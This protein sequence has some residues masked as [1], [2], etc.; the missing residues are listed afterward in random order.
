MKI[1]KE[2]NLYHL[3]EDAASL[4]VANAK[5]EAELKTKES[6]VNKFI[7]VYYS[8]FGCLNLYY[9]WPQFKWIFNQFSLG[10]ISWG[11]VTEFPKEIRQQRCGVFTKRQRDTQTQG[12][13]T[14]QNSL[15]HILSLI[16]LFL[17]ILQLNMISLFPER[18]CTSCK[19]YDIRKLERKQRWREKESSPYHTSGKSQGQL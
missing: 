14:F 2:C 7:F 12:K 13:Y 1:F 9:R 4:K 17:R 11:W 10:H 5:L 18:T 3:Q 19:C 6:E 8:Y 16:K 15:F